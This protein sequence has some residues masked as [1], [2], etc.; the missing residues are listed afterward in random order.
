[1]YN[2]LYVHICIY[3]YIY[4]YICIYMYIYVYTYGFKH[5]DTH[6]FNQGTGESRKVF[7][8][9]ALKYRMPATRT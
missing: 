3:M 1:M 8:C 7:L 4:V 2:I 5:T 6:P 9:S